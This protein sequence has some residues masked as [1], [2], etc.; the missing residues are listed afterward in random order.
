MTYLMVSFPDRSIQLTNKGNSWKDLFDYTIVS[1][2]KPTFYTSKRPFRQYDNGRVNWDK[3]SSLEKGKVYVEGN[4]AD[5]ERF[6]KGKGERIVYF[7][8][9]LLSD[10]RE[11]S[12]LSGWKTVVLISELDQEI[13]TQSNPMFGRLINEAHRVC[14]TF[15]IVTHQKLETLTKKLSLGA[16]EHIELLT[17]IQTDIVKIRRGKCVH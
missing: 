8:D 11:P 17:D 9:H 5:F 15:M 2:D 6:T 4:L 10:V 7:G 12:R 3:V 16:N 14:E 1:A 13:Q